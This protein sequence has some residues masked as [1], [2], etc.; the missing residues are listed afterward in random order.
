MMT[1]II[2]V[3]QAEIDPSVPVLFDFDSLHSI[4]VIAADCNYSLMLG[5]SDDSI[6][7]NQMM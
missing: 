5:S 1:S 3:K 6:D 7:D 4:L 2:G